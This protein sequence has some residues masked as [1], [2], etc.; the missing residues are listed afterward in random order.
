MNG[1]L[2]TIVMD[3]DLFLLEF[4]RFIRIGI[5]WINNDTGK[6]SSLILGIWKAESNITLAWRK[7]INWHEIGQ[8]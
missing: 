2:L 5:A 3:N 1:F 8:T 6:A 7:R 4:F